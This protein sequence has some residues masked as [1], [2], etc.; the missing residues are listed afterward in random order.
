MIARSTW[1]FDDMPQGS[2]DRE[3]QTERDLD[4]HCFAFCI[5]LFSAIPSTIRQANKSFGANHC[6]LRKGQFEEA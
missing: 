5:S 2:F 6:L 4:G 1:Y 3:N